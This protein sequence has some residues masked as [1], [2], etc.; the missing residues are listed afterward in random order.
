MQRKTVNK[1][2]KI[3]D[4]ELTWEHFFHKQDSNIINIS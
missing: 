2:M 4:E 3:N 1:N